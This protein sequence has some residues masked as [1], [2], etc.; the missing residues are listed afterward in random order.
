MLRDSQGNKSLNPTRSHMRKKTKNVTEEPA[1][2]TYGPNTCGCSVE[3]RVALIQQRA[4]QIFEQ[5]GRQPGHELDDWLQAER[6]AKAHLG[7]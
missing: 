6:E 2:L 7:A 5:R 3:S 1:G 4:Y